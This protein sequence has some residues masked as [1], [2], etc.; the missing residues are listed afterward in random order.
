MDA[1]GWPVKNARIMYVQ[2][3]ETYVR[4]SICSERADR[5]KVRK[6]CKRKIVDKKHGLP[7]VFFFLK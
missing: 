6:N 7:L 1:D 3:H 4:G 5:E 2:K